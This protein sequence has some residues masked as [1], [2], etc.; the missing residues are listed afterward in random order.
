MK[1]QEYSVEQIFEKRLWFL[2]PFF[3]FTFETQ[4][5]LYD[6]ESQKLSQL[7]QIYID[8]TERLN[9]YQMRKEITEFEKQTIIDMSKK[10]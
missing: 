6:S 9:Q 4:F 8:I 7:K 3:I 2:I 5:D 1:I 10:F